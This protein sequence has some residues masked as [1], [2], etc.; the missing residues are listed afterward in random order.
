MTIPAKSNPWPSEAQ[1]NGAAEHM[2]ISDLGVREQVGIQIARAAR[3]GLLS[4]CW[5]GQARRAVAAAIEAGLVRK[6]ITA[7]NRET[8][9]NGLQIG[10]EGTLGTGGRPVKW[11]TFHL[12]TDDNPSFVSKNTFHFTPY[13]YEQKAHTENQRNPDADF[14]HPAVAPE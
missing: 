7:D 1:A 11:Q 9:E 4:H 13:H 6:T 3:L 8:P 10:E 12:T 2:N 5:K 14:H